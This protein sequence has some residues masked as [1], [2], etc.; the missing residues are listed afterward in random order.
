MWSADRAVVPLT[1]EQFHERWKAHALLP[2]MTSGI[3]PYV[4]RVVQCARS[5]LAGP[6]DASLEVD[7]ANLLGLGGPGQGLWCVRPA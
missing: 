1:C 7:G 4:T 2:G 3:R 6:P 5:D